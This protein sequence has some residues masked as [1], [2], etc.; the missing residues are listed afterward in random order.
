MKVERWV[1]TVLIVGLTIA[2]GV[3]H[4]VVIKDVEKEPVMESESSFLI[5]D[6]SREDGVSAMGN[7]WRMFTDRVM[8]GRSSG[9][10]VYRI[11]QGRRCLHLTGSISLANN[12]GFIQVALPLEVKG[13]SFN[14]SGY[15]GVKLLILGN[16]EN[17]HV[18]LRTSSNRLP[19][20][21]YQGKFPSTRG[22]WTEIRIPFEQFRGQSVR[23]PLDIRKLTRIA[24]VAIKKEFKADIAISR[25]EFYR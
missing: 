25:I 4:A 14:A 9:E 18:H 11:I 6:F 24:V 15:T 23:V 5:D 16:G 10:S 3:G 12:G 2:A 19:W 8:G 7:R 20:Q 17:Y 13:K 22:K 1:K 21:F